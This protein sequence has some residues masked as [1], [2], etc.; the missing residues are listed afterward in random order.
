MIDSDLQLLVAPMSNPC[1]THQLLAKAGM[2][3]YTT[4]VLA[5]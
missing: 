3:A 2:E 5:L 4:L 1:V